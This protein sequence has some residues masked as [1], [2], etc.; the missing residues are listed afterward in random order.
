MSEITPAELAARTETTVEHLRELQAAGIL[1]PGPDGG[2]RLGDVHRV[3]IADAF[4]ESGIALQ[5]LRS[6]SEAGAISFRYYDLLHPSPGR[7]SERTYAELRASFGDDAPLLGQLFG[8]F[9]LAEPDEDARL[10]A[11]DEALLLELREL[12][13][14]IGEADLALRVIRLLGDSLRRAT[15]AVMTV[16]DEAVARV[17]EPAEGLPSQEVFDAYLVPW[18][19]L[20]QVAPRM[21]T[22]LTQRHLSNAIDAYSVN[23]TEH[24]LALGG[25]VPTRTDAP[26]AIA[27]VDLSGFTRL[28]EERGDEPVARVALEFGR[29]AE[30]HARAADGRL[31]KLL[32]DGALLRFPAAVAAV[33]ATRSLM[34]ALAGAGLPRGHAGIHAGPVIV[35]DGDIFGRTVN[36]ASRIADLA[37]ADQLLV[38]RAVADALPSGR[39]ALEAA[40]EAEVQGIGEAIAVYRVARA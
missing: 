9:G 11:D 14:A 16:Y 37:D 18:A 6:A 33:D 39:F 34:D 2:Y 30:E 40:G 36:L 20:A 19:G 38:T 28:A 22:W 8:A 3:R 31:V 29:L 13:A 26:P 23:S 10:E 17:I 32:G 21:A 27:F 35:R 4:L 12:T 1:S 15:E 5:A 24:F 25:Y 7:R